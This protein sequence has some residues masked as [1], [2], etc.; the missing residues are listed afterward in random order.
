[1]ADLRL[2]MSGGCRCRQLL[3]VTN[4]SAYKN[5]SMACGKTDCIQLK[6]CAGSAIEQGVNGGIILE[7]HQQ[8]FRVLQFCHG[9]H[10]RDQNTM[11]SRV[12]AFQVVC[13]PT[14]EPAIL[15][16]HNIHT[17]AANGRRWWMLPCS[18]HLRST[19]MHECGRPSSGCKLT[20]F[21]R[22][23]G[24][25]SASTTY[26]RWSCCAIHREPDVGI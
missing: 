8:S 14:I 18:Y 19:I 2:A 12:L 11:V 17:A 1:M 21:L 23:A 24:L 25:N 6:P 10:E 9:G 20:S 4:F 16:P 13:L 15:T 7:C 22:P 26:H 5:Q 3:S